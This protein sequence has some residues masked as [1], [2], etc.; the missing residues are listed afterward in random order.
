M[1]DKKELGQDGEKTTERN[2]QDGQRCWGKGNE[3]KQ[4][5]ERKKKERRR[6]EVMLDERESGQDG[7]REKKGIDRMDGGMLESRQI[8]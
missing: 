5:E 7:Q 8:E 6:D 3:R 1:L 2:R 4:S